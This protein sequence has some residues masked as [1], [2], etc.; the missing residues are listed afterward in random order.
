MGCN[1]QQLQDLQRTHDESDTSSEE[2]VSKLS[3]YNPRIKLKDEA[4]HRQRYATQSTGQP[5]S[6]VQ[7]TI[8]NREKDSSFELR[9]L[10]PKSYPLSS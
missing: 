8:A 7:S 6:L 2:E 10:P 3:S 9:T 5:P 1:C 4:T